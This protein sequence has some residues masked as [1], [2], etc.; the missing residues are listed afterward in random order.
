M[1]KFIKI[2]KWTGIVL[3]LLFVISAGIYLMGPVPKAEKVDNYPLPIPDALPGEDRPDGLKKNNEARI[4]WA[5]SVGKQ[6]EY[7]IVYL[8]GF[9]ASPMEADPIHRN[10]AAAY[11][12]NL[13]L[14]RLTEHGIDKP[15]VFEKLS[16][17]ALVQSAKE[18]IAIGKKIGKKVI[19]MSCSTGGTLALYLSANDPEISANILFSPNIALADPNSAL[20]TGPWGLQLG[21]LFMGGKNRE[22]KPEND[23]VAQ[24]WTSKYRVEGVIAMKQLLNMTMNAET[25]AKVKQPLFL[26]YYYKNEKEQDHTVSVPAMLSMFEK[27]GTPSD[28]KIKKAFPDA[29]VHVICSKWQSKDLKNLELSLKDFMEKTLG[30]K[31]I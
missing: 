1:Q 22:W 8:H 25:F 11:G 7:S 30:L 12:C 18:A 23:S 13:Y 20:L 21:R 4:I 14:A 6:S 19:L 27:L 3:S 10:I 29:G 31:P 26:G 28:K 2:I 16:P 9:S 15:D 17:K 24:Y 5:D